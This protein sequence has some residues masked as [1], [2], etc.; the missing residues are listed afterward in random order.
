MQTSSKKLE[1]SEKE[2][3]LDQFTTLL[4]D[5]DHPQEMRRFLSTFLS[6]TEISVLSKRLASMVLLSQG[7]SY[8]KIIDQLHIS[9]A[10]ISS[11]SDEIE[12]P[13]IKSAVKKIQR[14]ASIQ[15]FFDALFS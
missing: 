5:I 7:K 2:H 1:S 14:S 4:C 10:T 8:Q 13:P 9:S 12:K 3:V 15:R 11:A 6:E